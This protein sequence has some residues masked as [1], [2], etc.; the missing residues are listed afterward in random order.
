[1]LLNNDSTIKYA[2]CLGLFYQL[3]HCTADAC[4]AQSVVCL[5]LCPLKARALSISMVT[6]LS[7][8][9]MVVLI[10][11]WHVCLCLASN[12]PLLVEDFLHQLH[13]RRSACPFAN[14][15]AVLTALLF[16]NLLEIKFQTQRHRLGHQY[17]PA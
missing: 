17:K 3:V 10:I 16:S 13:I 5:G 14:S 6:P 15:F 7:R 9:R 4:L 2:A 1:M 11:I 8:T 12:L